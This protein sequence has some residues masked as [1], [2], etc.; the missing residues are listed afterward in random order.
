MD[1]G[2]RDDRSELLGMRMV[3]SGDFAPP[4][5]SMAGFTR[6]QAMGY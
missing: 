5:I 4:A 2:M 1:A 6:A 3:A